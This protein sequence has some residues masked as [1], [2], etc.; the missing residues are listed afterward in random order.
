MEY[1]SIDRSQV[2]EYLRLDKSVL[3]VVLKSDIRRQGVW[4]MRRC[5]VNEINYILG[6]EESVVF[7]VA[8]VDEINHKK[9]V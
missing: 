6:R 4:D 9:E 7:Y 5:E 8:K 2:W 3:M 1:I